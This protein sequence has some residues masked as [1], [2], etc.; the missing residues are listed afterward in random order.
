MP[1][2]YPLLSV[3]EQRPC[4]KERLPSSFSGTWILL[5]FRTC[6]RRAHI[7]NKTKPNKTQLNITQNSALKNSMF[8]VFKS[9]EGKLQ[10]VTHPPE[11]P[12]TEHREPI[13]KK[14]RFI[15]VSKLRDSGGSRG[16]AGEELGSHC[17]SSLVAS[18][19]RER[20][21]HRAQTP[22]LVKHYFS[23]LSFPFSLLSADRDVTQTLRAVW[24]QSTAW[25]SEGR[26]RLWL[27]LVPALRN[28]LWKG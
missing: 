21:R 5:L 22:F 26:L 10:E 17:W 25:F 28:T 6:I 4:A 12:T 19:G 2:C 27:C 14:K 18:C 13:K 23:S 3:T 15:C 24:G 16:W 20:L 11:E 9:M 7:W 1:A 8:H